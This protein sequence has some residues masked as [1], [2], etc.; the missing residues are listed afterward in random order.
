MS[1]GTTYNTVGNREGLMDIL[2]N[3][4]P[5]ETP[6]FTTFKKRSV[7]S[8]KPEW[9][10]EA[11][12]TANKDNA[13]VENATY[14][15]SSNFARTRVYNY[16]QIVENVVGVSDTQK[17]VDPAGIADELAHQVEL[18]MTQHKLDLEAALVNQTKAAGD[19]STA[20]K[21]GGIVEWITTN[22]SDN[23]GTARAL[24]SDILNDLI[25]DVWENGGKPNAIF[26]NGTQKRALSELTTSNTKF[27]DAKEKTV[28]NSVDVYDSDFGRLTVKLSRNIASDEML[29]MQEN[30]WEVG[31]LRPVKVNTKAKTGDGQ[32]KVVIGEY[33]LIAKNEKG[34]GIIKDLS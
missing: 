12:A 9:L 13:Q 8:T 33:T 19:A 22:V 26:V 17:A 25:E 27:I 29:I 30:L 7:S 24:T 20:R 3:I 6:F 21:L 4:S 31:V 32:E 16:T 5:D 15:A 23:G 18:A 1:V 34:S 14:A 10:T 28:V 2:T 11:L